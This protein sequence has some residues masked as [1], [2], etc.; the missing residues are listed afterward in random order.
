MAVAKFDPRELEK[1]GER[2]LFMMGSVPLYDYP[3]TPREAYKELYRRR[4]VWQMT[5]IDSQMFA[6][7]INPDNIA[8]AMVMDGGAPDTVP[9]GGKD[10]F[11]IEWEFV[12]QVGG[13]MVRPGKPLLEDAN[14]WRETIVWPDL[15]SWD[16]NAAT[17][18]NESYLSDVYFNECWLQN[19]WFER[20]ITFMDFE[21]AIMALFDDDQKD[22]VKELFDKLSDFYIDLLGRFFRSFPKIDAMF[23]HDDWGSQKESFF[24]PALCEEMVVPYMRKV[25]DY[26][27]S[28]GRVAELHSC[29]QIFKQVP[30][31]IAA[32]W[33]TW[34]G[35]TMNDSQKIYE[36]YGD[37]LV[38][39]VIPDVFDPENTSPDEQRARA[40]RYAEK[41]CDP[42]RP[43]K[44]SAYGMSMLTPA[45]RE[46]LYKQS[47]MRYGG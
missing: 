27:H 2:E 28:T 16:W 47:R 45:F 15:D 40:R 1:A 11:G 33:D 6:P 43:S 17:R 24:S 25:T 20:L 23:I 41:F 44:F 42:T 19:G 46:E 9:Q 13:S 12:R 10:M 8:R 32:G 37:S 7:R 38:L 35:Q 36:V 5:S 31:I 4:P 34:Y 3:V 18:E 26:I 21:G 30:N 39:G 14:D 29:G 22:A